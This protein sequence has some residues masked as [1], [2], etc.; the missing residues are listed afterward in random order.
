V[1]P[2][3]G[4][5]IRACVPLL[6]PVIG[7]AAYNLAK[8]SPCPLR[9]HMATEGGWDVGCLCA[10]LLA[11]AIAASGASLA[12]AILLALPGVAAQALLLWRNYPSGAATVET[13]PSGSRA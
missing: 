11:A 7:G 12:L 1:K 3:S 9:F 13:R 8:A 10:C 2:S 5:P 6:S 4:L